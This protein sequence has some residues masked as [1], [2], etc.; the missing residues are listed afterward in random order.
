MRDRPSRKVTDWTGGNGQ[1]QTEAGRL[2]YR[3]G[4][5]FGFRSSESNARDRGVY[6]CRVTDDLTRG[7]GEQGFM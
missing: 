1:G 2:R 4:F 5:W 6:L 3:L 7:S